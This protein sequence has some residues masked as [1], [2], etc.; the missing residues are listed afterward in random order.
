MIDF[1]SL[2]AAL[3]IEVWSFSGAWLLVLGAS[4]K[5]ET[6]FAPPCRPSSPL[7]PPFPSA[8]LAEA[9]NEQREC[10][11]KC[12]SNSAKADVPKSVFIHAIPKP[13]QDSPTLAKPAQATSPGRGESHVW[14]CGQAL[15]RWCQALSSPVKQFSGKKRLFISW[16]AGLGLW[17][18]G[19]N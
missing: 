2:T 16:P 19:A 9:P 17:L 1:Q 14:I 5:C 11:Y 3:A 7:L 15:S 4:S 12:C 18:P 6:H 8:S 10:L 13:S